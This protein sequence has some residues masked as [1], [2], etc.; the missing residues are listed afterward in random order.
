METEKNCNI[1]TPTL[2]AITALL[3]RSPGLLNIFSNWLNFLC[4]ELYNCSKSTF[5]FALIQPVHGQGYILIFLH[6]MH[7]LFTQ[8]HFL[9]WQPGRVGGQYTT[10]LF[11]LR[12][13]LSLTDVEL[14][15]GILFISMIGRPKK[16]AKKSD[17]YF[18]PFQIWK[19]IKRN[20]YKFL[21]IF[22]YI[23]YFR[24][25]ICHPYTPLNVNTAVVNKE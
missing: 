1:W 19:I 23:W 20:I 8:V 21:G 7:L 5:F 4:T 3:S 2:M 15:K 6:R 18:I 25:W 16:K 14:Q 9:F 12:S 13:F 10:P 22:D 24:N 11:T 17:N